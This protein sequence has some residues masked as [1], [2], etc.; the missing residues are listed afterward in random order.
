M[1]ILCYL[2]SCPGQG[3]YLSA[4]NDLQLWACCD[5]DWASCPMTRRSLIGYFVMLGSLPISWKAKKQTKASRSS[6]EVEYRSMAITTCELIWFQNLLCSLGVDHPKPM[7]LFCVT[8]QRFTLRLILFSMRVL[9]ISKLI[10]ILFANG[11]NSMILK[12]IMCLVISNLSIILLKHWD[13]SSFIFCLA[14]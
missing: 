3:I 13:D 10:V 4:S 7:R 12:P 5:A 14:S 9:N 2:K 8:K 1:R 6:A 11:F